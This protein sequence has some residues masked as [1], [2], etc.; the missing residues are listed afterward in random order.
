MPNDEDRTVGRVFDDMMGEGYWEST[1]RERVA[2]L[3]RQER[4]RQD[5]VQRI[6]QELRHRLNGLIGTTRTDEVQDVARAYIQEATHALRSYGVDD[7]D[8]EIGPSPDPNGVMIYINQ[9]GPRYGDSPLRVV[10]DST[11]QAMA[12]RQAQIRMIA[13]QMALQPIIH[14]EGPA[15]PR[16]IHAPNNLPPSVDRLRRAYAELSP[17]E[18][19]QVAAVINGTASQPPEDP[20]KEEKDTTNNFL[21]QRKLEID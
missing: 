12:A 9:R 18:R 7:V 19:R 5:I 16:T 21:P 3:A 17:E 11:A 10:I 13:E 2:R 1:R 20:E 8:I 4:E 6:T 15:V 14:F